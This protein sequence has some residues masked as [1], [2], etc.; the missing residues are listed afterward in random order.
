MLVLLLLLAL[1][2]E[3]PRAEA[4]RLFALGNALTGEGDVRGAIAAYEGA[5][6]TGWTSPELE[7]NLS[8]AHA[9]AGSL[10]RAVLHAE[11]ARRLA[12]RAEPVQHALHRLRERLGT[13]PA[14]RSPGESAARWL[15]A[16]IGASGITALLLVL[17]VGVLGLVG[18]RLWTG[19]APPAL[20]RSLVVLAPLAVFVAG[21]AALARATRPR[22]EPSPWP[23]R[24]CGAR[25][26]PRPLAWATRAKAPCSSSPSGAGRG[27]PSASPTAARA[28]SRRLRWKRSDGF[29]LRN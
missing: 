10:G 19:A 27:A 29:G 9:E 22:P 13:E 5:A 1:P 16:H 2:D 28:G 24:R 6:A 18:V 15:S 25:P 17:W 3:A 23:E 8:H 26:R 4:E 11:R 14:A 7:L 12:P 20:R 21:G